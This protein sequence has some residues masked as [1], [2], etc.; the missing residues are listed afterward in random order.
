MMAEQN[1][2][3]CTLCGWFVILHLMICT[4]DPLWLGFLM[5][6]F[7]WLHQSAGLWGNWRGG[8]R[9]LGPSTQCLHTWRAS[10]RHVCIWKGKTHRKHIWI[11]VIVLVKSHLY[12]SVYMKLTETVCVCCL[13]SFKKQQTNCVCLESIRT[14]LMPSLLRLGGLFV[15]YNVNL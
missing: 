14:E 3:L 4:F 8:E 12:L 2:T 15:Y 6:G 10:S 11:L 5:T 7:S 9:P 13:K 1:Y